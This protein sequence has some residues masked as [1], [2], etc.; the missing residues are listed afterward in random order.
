M[1]FRVSRGKVLVQIFDLDEQNFELNKYNQNLKRK[2]IFFI[3]HPD[4]DRHSMHNKLNNLCGIF[5]VKIIEIP[6]SE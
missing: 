5:G 4:G 2:S 6:S 1:V 3:A